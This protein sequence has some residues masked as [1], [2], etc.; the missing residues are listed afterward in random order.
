MHIYESTYYDAIE[1]E[2]DDESSMSDKLKV[3]KLRNELLDI[4]LANKEDEL[5]RAT[6]L[7]VKDAWEQYQMLLKL[8]R[9]S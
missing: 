8:A 1:D 2:D 5:V 9:K 3:A 7:G 6:N 4:T